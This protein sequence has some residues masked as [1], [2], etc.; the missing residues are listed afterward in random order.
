MAIAAVQ[1]LNAEELTVDHSPQPTTSF[2]PKIMRRMKGWA[3]DALNPGIGALARSS[4]CS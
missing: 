1:G 4:R 2:P 3:S